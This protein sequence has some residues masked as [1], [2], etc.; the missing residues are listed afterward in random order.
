MYFRAFLRVIRGASVYQFSPA[1]QQ[2]NGA[3]FLQCEIPIQWGCQFIKHDKGLN[4]SIVRCCGGGLA[5][6][7]PTGAAGQ[8]LKVLNTVG[9]FRQFWAAAAGKPFPEQEGLGAKVAAKL[10]AQ[11]ETLAAMAAWDEP[12]YETKISAVLKAMAAH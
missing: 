3:D 8:A 11:D 10:A 9:D 12:E 4:V 7:A 2:Q 5:L 1:R 6:L